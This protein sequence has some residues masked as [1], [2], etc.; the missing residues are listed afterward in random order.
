MT[1]YFTWSLLTNWEWAA[2]FTEQFGV[3]NVNFATEERTVKASARYLAALFNG[4][5]ANSTISKY[6]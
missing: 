6:D 3:V 5:G 2:G 4:A 1:G